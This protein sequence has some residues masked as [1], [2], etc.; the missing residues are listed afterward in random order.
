LLDGDTQSAKRRAQV[1]LRLDRKSFSAAFVSM[2]L[3]AG[4]GDR[5]KAQRI[6]QIALNTPIDGSGRTVAQSLAR[7]GASL[8]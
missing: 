6:F 3:A 1:A 5:D 8:G 7:L 4:A 2:L